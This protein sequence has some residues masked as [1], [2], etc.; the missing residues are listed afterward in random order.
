MCKTF[1]TTSFRCQ[2]C[3]CF[4][5]MCPGMTENSEP[6]EIPVPYNN[7]PYSHRNF[8]PTGPYVEY[9]TIHDL[10]WYQCPF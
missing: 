9:I 8:E 7:T 1:I 4:G 2:E 6:V 3:E 5:E 10:D